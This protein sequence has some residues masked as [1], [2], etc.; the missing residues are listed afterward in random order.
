VLPDTTPAIVSTFLKVILVSTPIIGSAL[1]AFTKQYF[2]RGDYLVMRAGAEEVLKEI[3]N[4]RTILKG[5]DDRRDWLDKRLAD[6]RRQVYRGLS[7]EMNIPD[8]EGDVPLM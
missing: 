3:Y 7:G 2:M 8:Y 6:I 4:Y 1:A 5:K